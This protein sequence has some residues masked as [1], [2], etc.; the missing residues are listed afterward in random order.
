VKN[1]PG[2]YIADALSGVLNQSAVVAHG[3]EGDGFAG[4]HIG[5]V[6]VSGTIRVGV[7]EELTL[8]VL[9]ERLPFLRQTNQLLGV[10][11]LLRGEVRKI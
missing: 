9:V 3:Q 6:I 4:M 11:I 5:G 7:Q 1:L 2:T 10:D 8:D